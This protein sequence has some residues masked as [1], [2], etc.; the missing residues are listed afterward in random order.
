MEPEGSLPCSQELSTC[1]YPEPDQ[2]EHDTS[3][4][5]GGK[6]LCGVFVRLYGY[7]CCAFPRHSLRH[8]LV[9]REVMP[10]TWPVAALTNPNV[11]QTA[12]D[13]CTPLIPLSGPVSQISIIGHFILT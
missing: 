5:I 2:S 10:L 4:K 7:A 11:F 3:V 6:S 13:I 8:L 12:P 9:L 1:P